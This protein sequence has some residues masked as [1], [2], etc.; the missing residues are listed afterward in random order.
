MAV[1][2]P[3]VDRRSPVRLPRECYPFL[4]AIEEHLGV[5]RPAQQRGLVLW[6]YGTLLAQSGCQS[7]VLLALRP[8]FGL[9]AQHA[10]RQMLREWH[11]DGADKT[12][13]G[14]HE[15][16]VDACF[17]PLLGWVLAWWHGE[18]LALALDAT[19]LGE[20]LVVLS[21]SVL[22]RGSAI[23]VAWHV[24]ANRH[25]PWLIPA[26]AVLARLGAA[27]PAGMEVLVLADRGLWSPK[28]WAGVRALGWHPVLRLRPDVTFRPV[29]GKRV[30]AKGLVP[31][32]GHAW[33]GTGIA[34][35]H[36]AV[37]RA[38]TLLVVWEADHAEPWICLTDL[39]PT[40]IGPAWYGLRVW[41]E[42]GFRTLK[43]LGWH[44]ERTRRTDPQRVARHWLV[45]AIATL[46]TVAVGTRDEDA[47]RWG[48]E[49]A[50]VRRVLPPSPAPFRRTISVFSRGLTWLRWQLLRQ[51]RLWR[52]L[53]LWPEPWP[54]PPAGLIVVVA[55]PP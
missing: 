51:R 47:Q 13:P 3:S 40:A 30:A 19:A 27:V 16:D 49:P 1:V 54:D 46:W 29:G 15:V 38:G 32:P 55:T 42:L 52:L 14:R 31:G 35:K 36:R 28:V 6:V 4:A 37:R 39:A 25:G 17:A 8:V 21:V 45:L 20:R 50:G 26:L 23:P 11:L 12:L 34:F 7:A 2:S 10:L 18:A 48:R 41:V 9:A 33:I 24:S 43:S 53:W 44:W 22:Y 5:L